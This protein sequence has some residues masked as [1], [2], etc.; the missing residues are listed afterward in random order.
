MHRTSAVTDKI[1]ELIAPY[2]ASLGLVLWGVELASEGHRQ[3]V[4]LFLDLAP[5][6]PR[7]PE[8]RGVTIDECAKVSRHLGTLLEVEE[9]FHSPYVLEVS[10]PGIG[11]RFFESQQLSAY[12]GKEIEAKLTLPRD[13]RKR[14]RGILTAVAGNQLSMTVDVGPKSFPLTFDFEQADKIRL[15]HALVAISEGGADDGGASSGT[16]EVTP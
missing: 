11:R 1:Q 12:I 7:T 5:E 8:R 16:S 13:G 2:L 6:T 15:I 4:R 9:L 3:L 10:S 14:F